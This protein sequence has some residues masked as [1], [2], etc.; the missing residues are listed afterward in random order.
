M[1][2]CRQKKILKNASSRVAKA[3]KEYSMKSNQQN[4]IGMFLYLMQIKA[5]LSANIFVTSYYRFLG[6]TPVHM[7]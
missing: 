7:R 1:S 3:F 4:H 2:I 5:A 6:S